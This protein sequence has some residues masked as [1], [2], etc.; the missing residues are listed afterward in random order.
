MCC[1]VNGDIDVGT[2]ACCAAETRPL[3]ARCGVERMQIVFSDLKFIMVGDILIIL[4]VF[5]IGSWGSTTLSILLVEL[6]HDWVRDRLK[7]L[8]LLIVVILFGGGVFI[9]PLD[10]FIGS[11]LDGLLVFFG[12]LAS[13]LLLVVDLVFQGVSESFKTVAGVDV[14]FVLLILLGVVLGLTN[15]ALN[16]LLGETSLISSDGDRLR[17]SL[18]LVLSRDTDNTVSV[19]LEGDL[20]LRNAT[21]GRRDAG[22]FEFTEENIVLG[23]GT[24]TLENLDENSRLVV[25]I[26]G[27]GLRLLRGNDSVALNQLGHHTADSLDTHGKGGNVK[28]EDALG[29]FPSLTR[30][31]TTLDSSTIGNSFVRVNSPVGFLPVEEVLDELLNLWDTSRS[32]DKNNLV[33]LV[34]LKARVLHDVRH[35]LQ[36]LAE[37]V[38]VE[39]FESSTGKSLGEILAV[40]KGLD[41]NLN[42]VAGGESTLSLFNLTAKF[43]KGT[44]V[45]GDVLLGLLLDEL[46][47]VLHDA[48]VEVF[49]SKVGVPVGGKHLENTLVNS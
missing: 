24:L 26:G 48:L 11:F 25:L 12:D 7:F 2:Y 41:L 37:E 14:L 28:Q 17:V 9:K 4:E 20:N 33:D 1:C 15:H 27:E 45:L 8:F 31:N 22:E 13:E 30:K 32:T 16:F 49:T 23:H 29:L 40:N 18:S 47:E 44:V 6:S 43:G 42:L 10:H 34:L 5:S 36:S 3:L 38:V 19:D 35:W 21:R 39:L 46:D